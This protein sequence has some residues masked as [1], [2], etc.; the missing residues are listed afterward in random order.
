MTKISRNDPCPCGSGKK[1]KKCCGLQE[2]ERVRKR[3]TTNFKPFT[4]GKPSHSFAKK[5]FKVLS[6]PM[7]N[8]TEEDQEKP[9]RSLEKFIGLGTKN[10]PET[11]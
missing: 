5:V 6:T 8:P 11:E 3:R 10:S 2:Q 1:Y 9:H 7:G 4:G